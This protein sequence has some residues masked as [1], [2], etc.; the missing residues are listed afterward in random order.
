VVEFKMDMVLPQ[1]GEIVGGNQV[2]FPSAK[3]VFV[4]YGFD[5]RSVLVYVQWALDI[6]TYGTTGK[7]TDQMDKERH[8][9][10]DVL[11]SLGLS[12][13][14]CTLTFMLVGNGVANQ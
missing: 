13:A 7:V 6:H 3:P 14:H 10:C 9:R 12:D 5:I 2:L 11:L 4:S 8:L 1:L